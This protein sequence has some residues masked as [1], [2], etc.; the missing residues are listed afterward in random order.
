MA[1]VCHAQG[2]CEALSNTPPPFPVGP[3]L[4]HMEAKGSV[5]EML[6]MTGLPPPHPRTLP[7]W[8]CKALLPSPAAG[9]LCFRS[10]GWRRSCCNAGGTWRL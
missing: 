10:M 6:G 9:V 5:I 8:K 2:S 3:R 4:Y 7:V 1:G